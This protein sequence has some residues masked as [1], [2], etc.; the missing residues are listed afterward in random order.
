MEKE[1]YELAI[2]WFK[3]ATRIK[4]NL[5]SGAFVQID[6]YKYIPYLN[7]C[8]C[9][10]RLGKDKIACKYNEKA[11]KFKPNSI[12]YKN[13]KEYFKKIKIC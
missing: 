5:Q 10:N 11:G 3:Q 12:A 6:Y 9:Y 4:P 1:N 8:V 13:N 7:L 2:Y